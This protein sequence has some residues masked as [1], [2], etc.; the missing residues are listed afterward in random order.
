MAAAA[1]ERV[2]L[3]VREVLER[4]C[5]KS[6]TLIRWGGDEFLVV[7]RGFDAA[8]LEVIPERIRS[9]LEATRYDLGNQQVAYMSCSMGFTCYPFGPAPELWTL[10][11]D[12]VVAVAD[13][14][15]Y[16]AKR[17]GRNTW[18]GLMGTARTAIED[19]LQTIHES[20]DRAVARGGPTLATRDDRPHAPSGSD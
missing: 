9:S 2:L 1:G 5:R 8:N 15:L 3:Q 17:R 6:D 16:M 19:I 13:R 11:L 10:S 20:A 7:A 12:Q 18:V 14:A 4:A